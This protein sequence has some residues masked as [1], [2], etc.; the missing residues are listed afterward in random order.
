MSMND[1]AGV[2]R[3]FPNVSISTPQGDYPLPVVMIA[4]A[5]AESS[6][7]PTAKGD[8]GLGGP[9]CN[10]YTSWGLWQIHNTHSG[11]LEANTG[12][13]DPCKW[14]EWLYDP[15]NNA[16]AAAAIID[17]YSSPQTAVEGAWY[18]TWHENRYVKYLGEAQAAYQGGSATSAT[19]Q[20]TVLSATNTST[21]SRVG[22]YG[23]LALLIVVGILAV[24]E[25]AA[26]VRSV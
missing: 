7:V 19:T 18:T 5:G 26:V 14:A 22:E 8:Y 15:T 25:L 4:I 20:A 9:N 23:I 17:G 13:S 12:S 10:G 24:R 6:F 16:K 11:Y 21:I 2:A 3:I 1:A